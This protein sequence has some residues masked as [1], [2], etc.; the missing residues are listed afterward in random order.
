MLKQ[1]A[2]A[3]LLMLL[4]AEQ[5]KSKALREQKAALKAAAEASGTARKTPT[6]GSLEVEV[7]AT[8]ALTAVLQHH[9]SAVLHSLLDGR[10]AAVRR[11]GLHVV[12][13]MLTQG[14]AHP[15]K[16]IPYVMALELDVGPQSC[17]ARSSPPPS[18][19]SR[20]RRPRA[21]RRGP[22]SCT[23]CSTARSGS[24]T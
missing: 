23:R 21:R 20:P 5:E 6:E 9:Q 7:H 14:L 3:N 10:E 24:C 17:S 15:A 22:P 1:Q 16:C 2:L 11:E 4:K 18:S 12:G 13:A 19:S 8:A